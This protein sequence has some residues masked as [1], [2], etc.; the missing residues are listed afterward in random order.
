MNDQMDALAMAE[1]D[2]KP[3]RAHSIVLTAGADTADGLAWELRRLADD[4]ERERL[5]QGCS[6]SPSS[7]SIYSYKVRPVTHDEYF[8]AIDASLEANKS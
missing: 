5:T 4:I 1:D 8:A 7:G 6:G 2:T 3:Q